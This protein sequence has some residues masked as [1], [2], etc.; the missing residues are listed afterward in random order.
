[1]VWPGF[2]W[3]FAV[4]RLC[5]VPR[6]K[7][8][9]LLLLR[10]LEHSGHQQ[11]CHKP[12]EGTDGAAASHEDPRVTA[13]QDRDPPGCGDALRIG[14]PKSMCAR[15]AGEHRDHALLSLVPTCTSAPHGAIHQ[16]GREA[17]SSHIPRI[18]ITSSTRAELPSSE[19]GADVHF[20]SISLLQHQREAERSWQSKIPLVAAFCSKSGLVSITGSVSPAAPGGMEMLSQHREVKSPSQAQC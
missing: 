16:E 8:C 7:P 14:A 15:G 9:F 2:G 19:E 13:Q 6:D 11:S 3:S 5:S 12:E 18:S 4:V 10:V 17:R 20:A 1:M